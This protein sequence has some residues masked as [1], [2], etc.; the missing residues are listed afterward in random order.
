MPKATLKFRLPEEESEYYAASHGMEWQAVVW[1]L[2]QWLRDK[3]KYYSP[4]I[5]SE[6]Q[7]QLCEEIRKEIRLLMEG[8]CV[9][10]DA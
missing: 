9:M 4:A 3:L 6:D 7:R 1:E 5:L 2:D 10:F 8:R